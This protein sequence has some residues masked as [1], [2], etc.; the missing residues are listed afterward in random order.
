MELFEPGLHRLA[1]ILIYVEHLDAVSTSYTLLLLLDLMQRSVKKHI[2]SRKNDQLPATCITLG[3]TRATY[4]QQ[5]TQ[6]HFEPRCR[7]QSILA[8]VT[9]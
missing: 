1:A 4:S 7:P 6:A 2:D 5:V 3:L 8:A 9:F